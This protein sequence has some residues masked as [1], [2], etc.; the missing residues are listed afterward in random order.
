M[1]K[2][3][4]EMKS[5]LDTLEKLERELLKVGGIRELGALYNISGQTVSHWHNILRS[6]ERVKNRMIR[7]VKH[8][9]Y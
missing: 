4:R 8:E 9:T 5:E 2:G 3:T 1:K 7:G 6:K